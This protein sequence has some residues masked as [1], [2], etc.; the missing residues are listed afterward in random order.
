MSFYRIPTPIPARMPVELGKG[1]YIQ[2][3]ETSFKRANFE[4]DGLFVIYSN[5]FVG[6]VIGSN[7]VS[8]ILN[9]KAAD[10]VAYIDHSKGIHVIMKLSPAQQVKGQQS[11]PASANN[12]TEFS[13]TNRLKHLWIKEKVKR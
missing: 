4:K 5:K 11:E 3:L 10:S 6:D 7:M 8:T 2:R 13:P 9:Y 1:G 12:T